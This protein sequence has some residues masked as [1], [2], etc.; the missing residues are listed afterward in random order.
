[1]NKLLR[2]L[3]HPFQFAIQIPSKPSSIVLETASGKDKYRSFHKTGP[4]LFITRTLMVN[5][6]LT[7]KEIWRIYEKKLHESKKRGIE[8]EF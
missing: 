5:G 2:C 6:P 3:A 8:P 7:S 4:E 1:M